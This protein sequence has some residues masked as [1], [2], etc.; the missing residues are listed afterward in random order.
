MMIVL[1]FVNGILQHVR[2]GDKQ[3]CG[4]DGQAFKLVDDLTCL[5]NSKAFHFFYLVPKK[6]NPE[7]VLPIGRVDGDWCLP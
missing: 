2:R 7:S 6:V 3:I 4:I 5:L 1:N